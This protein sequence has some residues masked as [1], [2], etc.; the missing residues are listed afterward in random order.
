VEGKGLIF[1]QTDNTISQ[2][3]AKALAAHHTIK[4][5]QQFDETT[6]QPSLFYG[7][8]RG[9][10]R[11]MHILKH[12]KVDYW[13][14]DNGYIGAKYIDERNLKDMDGTYRVV[15][16]DMIELYGGE[17]KVEKKRAGYKALLF[18]PS[19][20]TANFYDM[21]PE[22]WVNVMYKILSARGYQVFK[23]DK[24]SHVPLDDDLAACDIVVNCNSMA[25]MRAVELGI[26]VYDTHWIFRNVTDLLVEDFIPH[27]CAT[28]NDVKAFYEPKQFTIEQ[29]RGWDAA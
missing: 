25:A 12:L 26:P 29:L 7:L 13:Y 28:W 23:R 4:H 15:K 24:Q 6:V 16:N 11:A 10:S 9:C 14:I 17:K 2:G 8:L 20:F 19:V 3:V 21:L 27:T 22:E 5:I 18:P 1:Y